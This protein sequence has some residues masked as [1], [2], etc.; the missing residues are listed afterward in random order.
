M[1]LEEIRAF[2]SIAQSG[3]FSRAA[4]QLHR[5]QP[6]I[7]RRIAQLEEELG[8]PL[9]DRIRGGALL[10]EAGRVFLPFAM[11][12]VAAIK[13]GTVA[14]RAVSCE[15][16]GSVSLAMVGTLADTRI[17][18]VLRSFTSRYHGV[19]L[20]LRTATSREVS[21]LVRSGEATMGLRYL[22]DSG[23]DLVCT[24]I[25]TESMV[26]VAGSEHPIAAVRG[27]DGPNFADVHWI[28]FPE[29]KGN[30]ES[31]GNILRR[32]L[33]IAGLD[34]VDIL[35][36]DSLT[37][38]K[39]LVEAGFGLAL[40]PESAIQNELRVGSLKVVRASAITTSV[41]ICVVH[42]RGGY[43]SNAARALLSQMTA[44]SLQVATQC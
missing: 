15:E 29:S 14:V 40:L 37:A 16:L 27:I 23:V 42:R 35:Y 22:A 44:D 38:Q 28:G 5:S 11:S 36:V 18:D 4:D 6:A 19:Q 32:Q 24:E 10:T 13:D 33:T 12:I 43:L 3:A 30:A 20:T 34:G 17:V 2:V 25:G 31:F 7:S 41:P 39:R 26:V 1:N 9:L 8:V 21:D